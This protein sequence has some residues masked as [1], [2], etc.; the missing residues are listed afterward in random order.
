MILSTTSSAFIPQVPVTSPGTQAAA[1]SVTS[2]TD[3]FP[4]IEPITATS[5]T[6][7]GTKTSTADTSNRPI[8]RSASDTVTPSAQTL[9]KEDP[10]TDV[11]QTQQQQQQKAEQKQ[12]ELERALIA[13]LQSRDKEVRAHEQA[14]QRVGGQYAG[15][16]AYDYQI[17][18]DYRQY[19]TGGEVSIDI[20]PVPGDPQATITK[21][22]IVKR[23]ALAPAE[24]SAQDR[25]AASQASNRATQARAELLAEKFRDMQAY[26]KQEEEN[27]T[28]ASPSAEHPSPSGPSA[29]YAFRGDNIASLDEIA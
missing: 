13:E 22:E 12:L 2:P 10:Q 9:S 26:G 5:K 19:A 11:N 24:P 14:H 20:S 18:P 29:A 4:A 27:T 3:A 1:S 28:D 7:N 16:P 25:Q 21:M 17:G 6:A 8:P 15:S 23:A